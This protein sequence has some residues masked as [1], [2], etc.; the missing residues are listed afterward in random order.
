MKAKEILFKIE[1]AALQTLLRLIG[2]LPLKVHYLNSHWVAALVEKVVRYRVNLVDDNLRHSFPEKTEA[3]R[4]EIRHQFYLH[5][6]RIFLEA[7]WFG[8]C[9]DPKRLRKAHIVEIA[10]PDLVTETFEKSSN[11]MVMYSHTGNWELLG[12]IASYNYTDKPMPLTEQNYC[13]VYRR[14]SSRLWDE[15]MRDNRFAPLEDREHF[16]GYLESMNIV[17]YAFR[18]KDN[19]KVYNMNTDQKPY[20]KS[21]DAIPVT[22]MNRP[23]KTM[24][25][26][27]ALARKFNMAVL[28]QRMVEVEQGRYSLEYVTICDDPSTMSVEQI[29]TRYYELL[30]ADLREQ[31]HNYL[32]THN[33]WWAGQ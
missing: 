20:F 9:R 8:A 21:P 22:F 32:W 28:Y 1:K 7:L 12:G 26:A 10:N 5:F 11:I 17:R 24:S 2:M 15:V 6:A 33:R 13:I 29:M 4:L 19:K 25:A 16:E 18:N 27:A 30:E 23:C 31:P 3:E 14:M